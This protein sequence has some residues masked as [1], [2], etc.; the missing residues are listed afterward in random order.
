VQDLM[1]GAAGFDHR[2]LLSRAGS[3]GEDCPPMF[4]R[5]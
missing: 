3:A 4:L 5:R 2:F 1:P